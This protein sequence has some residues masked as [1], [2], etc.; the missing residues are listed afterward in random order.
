MQESEL[1]YSG[2]ALKHGIF[3]RMN[4]LGMQQKLFYGDLMLIGIMHT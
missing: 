3:L 2:S 1:S 4:H